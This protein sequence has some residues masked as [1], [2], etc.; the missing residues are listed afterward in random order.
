MRK[1]VGPSARFSESRGRSRAGPA[2]G[3]IP[4]VSIVRWFGRI[5]RAPG[6]ILSFGGAFYYFGLARTAEFGPSVRLYSWG[7]LI[8]VPF[9]LIALLSLAGLKWQHF[10]VGAAIWVGVV[11]I[12]V[13]GFAQAQEAV[14]KAKHDLLSSSADPVF[15]ARWWPFVGNQLIYDPA[16]EQWMAND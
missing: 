14:F 2:L 6:L 11:L 8:L 7:L 15:E 9:L 5:V 3:K 4:R 13:E 10:V 12:G 16:Q 1:Q